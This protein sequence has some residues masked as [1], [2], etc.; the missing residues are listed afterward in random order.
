MTHPASAIIACNAFIARIAELEA[1]G[2][3]F[4]ALMVAESKCNE[5]GANFFEMEKA[6]T[7]RMAALGQEP[8]DLME[9]AEQEHQ[10]E[11]EQAIIEKFERPQERR[12][13]EWLAF[14]GDRYPNFDPAEENRPVF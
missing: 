12:F 11:I 2:C 5:A 4:N 8:I 10:A 6:Y 7:E 9:L 1:D 3:F 14:P 13:A